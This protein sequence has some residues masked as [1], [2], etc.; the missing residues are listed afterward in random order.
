MNVP[1]SRVSTNSE[2]M[3]IFF[4]NKYRIEGGDVPI[5]LGF[6]DVIFVMEDVDA[7]SK[8]VKRRDPCVEVDDVEEE[9][10]TESLPPPKSMW[11]MLL[12][13]SD[14][15][16][17]ELVK[18][19]T[20]KSNRLKEEACKPEVLRSIAQRMKVLPGLGLVGESRSS[21]GELDGSYGV[22]DGPSTA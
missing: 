17:K 19:L 4:D 1:L 13:S 14:E 6:K 3:S 15:S 18:E 20:E 16:C 9:V 2:L 8:V 7:A 12:E 21:G 5:R 11:R 10:S 22:A